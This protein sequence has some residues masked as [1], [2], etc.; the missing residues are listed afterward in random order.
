MPRRKVGSGSDALNVT[1]ERILSPLVRKRGFATSEILTQWPT[2]VG[3]EFADISQPEQ[4]KW[5]KG[6]ETDEFRPGTLVVRVSGA[7]GLILQHQAALIIQK[8][9]GYFGFPAVSRLQIVQKPFCSADVQ[10][11]VAR[12]PGIVADEEVSDIEQE[13]L[14]K[15]LKRLGEAVRSKPITKP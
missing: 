7:S 13:G 1:L 11:N 10:E 2:I 6:K 5:D 14:R 3:Q 4:V 9:N 12:I 8:V 15:A